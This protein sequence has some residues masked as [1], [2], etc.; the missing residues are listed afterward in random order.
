[1]HSALHY[2]APGNAGNLVNISGAAILKS[3]AHQDAAQKF[4]SYLVSPQGQ[5]RLTESESWEYPVLP[6]IPPSKGLPPFEEVMS[7]AVGGFRSRRRSGGAS[8]C[9][10]RRDCFDPQDEP[11]SRRHTEPFLARGYWGRPGFLFRRPASGLSF[12]A[13][14]SN[15]LAEDLGPDFQQPRPDA[16]WEYHPSRASNDGSVRRRPGWERLGWSR[17]QIY[18]A[19]ESGRFFWRCRWPFPTLWSATAGSL[20]FP[21]FM[22]S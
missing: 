17:R 3:S 9:S 14:D 18:L 4:L 12:V 11:P 5:T 1:M 2:Y 10:S 8:P 13:G 19:E 15:R 21:R 20:W 22:D 6:G 16:A 7:P